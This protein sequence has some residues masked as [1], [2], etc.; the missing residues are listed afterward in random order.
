MS[1]IL[2]KIY[3]FH[4]FTIL[5]FLKVSTH[6]IHIPISS[7]FA[8]ML[9]VDLDKNN[10]NGNY[11]NGNW[12]VVNSHILYIYINNKLEHN[13]RTT[14]KI[15]YKKNHLRLMKRK[16]TSSWCEVNLWWNVQRK[17]ETL[18]FNL[19]NWSFYS[20]ET[21]DTWNI[22]ILFHYCTTQ[23]V[24]NFFQYLF[25]LKDQTTILSFTLNSLSSYLKKLNIIK[26]SRSENAS[27]RRWLKFL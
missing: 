13:P 6:L 4:N 12:K 2:S 3:V 14:L 15:S 10:K 22:Y 21:K 18:H 17:L 7:Y 23:S 19:L 1:A 9:L 8:Y 25:S 27:K 11:M 26:M 16:K 24:R 5:V 20:F